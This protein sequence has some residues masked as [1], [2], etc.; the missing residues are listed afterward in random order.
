MNSCVRHTLF[1]CDTGQALASVAA[2][3]QAS[4]ESRAVKRR[5]WTAQEKTSRRAYGEDSGLKKIPGKRDIET[6]CSVALQTRIC[7]NIKDFCR[8]TMKLHQR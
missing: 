3:G 4:S 7:R 6:S 2:L 1:R 8:N 5:P